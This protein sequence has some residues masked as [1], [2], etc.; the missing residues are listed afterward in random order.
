MSLISWT[1][2]MLFDSCHGS[3]QIHWLHFSSTNHAKALSCQLS[4]VK[5]SRDGWPCLGT[6]QNLP[7]WLTLEHLLI[8]VTLSA[9][10]QML[11]WLRICSKNFKLR[12]AKM[13]YFS[14]RPALS[15][16]LRALAIIFLHALLVSTQTPK[17][18]PSYVHVYTYITLHV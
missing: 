6:V 13:D 14:V 9:S 17:Y 12:S 8:T 2:G 1:F 5:I 7:H 15:S 4:L 18:H 16:L 3:S 11:F 10:A